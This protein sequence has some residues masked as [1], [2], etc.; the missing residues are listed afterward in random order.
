[1]SSSGE[2]RLKRFGGK[3]AFSAW[4]LRVLAY[5]QTHGLK[6]TVT[7][8]SYVSGQ[9]IGLL[10]SSSASSGSS[11]SS[12]EEKKAQLAGLALRQK[13]SE[14]AYSLLLSLL[15]DHVIDL[16][17]HVDSGDAYG[18]WKVLIDTY[19]GKSTAKMCHLLDLLMNLKFKVKK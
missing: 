12:E 19:E 16:I 18:V 11:G 14:K 13:K 9:Q 2:P 17:A 8:E 1:M 10:S 5:L 15:E 4:K 3:G 6:E 7:S